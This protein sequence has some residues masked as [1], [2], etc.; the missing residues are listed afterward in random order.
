M[1]PA[2]FKDKVN[3][4]TQTN[5]T[6]MVDVGTQTEVQP[7]S[8]EPKPPPPSTKIYPGDFFKSEIW[9]NAKFDVN[10]DDDFDLDI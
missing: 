9:K 4:A 1:M 6:E 10:D 8:S 5:T 2:F 3:A 7:K